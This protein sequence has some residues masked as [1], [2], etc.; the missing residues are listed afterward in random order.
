MRQKIEEFISMRREPDGENFLFPVCDW[1]YEVDN[2]DTTA[3]YN[4]WLDDKVEFETDLACEAIERLLHIAARPFLGDMSEI[5]FNQAVLEICDTLRIADDEAA[6]RARQFLQME[7]VTEK[8]VFGE[9]CGNVPSDIVFDVSRIMHLGMIAYEARC[10]A[11]QMDRMILNFS[12]RHELT[13]KA[14]TLAK[15]RLGIEDEPAP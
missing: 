15:V 11:D 9:I 14:V 7:D 5:E 10:D 12:E 8:L 1:R 13:C 6:D 4:L 2:G 3:G